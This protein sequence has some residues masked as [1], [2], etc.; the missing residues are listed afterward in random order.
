MLVRSYLAIPQQGFP[1]LADGVVG[2]I[3]AALNRLYSF[4][5]RKCAFANTHAYS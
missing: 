4:G 1:T 5:A 2:N 3:T